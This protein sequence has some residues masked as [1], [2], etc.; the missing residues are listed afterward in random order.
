M[1][2]CCLVMARLLFLLALSLLPPATVDA[3]VV[4]KLKLQV[5]PAHG[6]RYAL[7]G[8]YDTLMLDGAT[9]IVLRLGHL[10][11]R[12]P[13][14]TLVAKGRHLRHRASRGEPGIASLKINPRKR[15][16]VVKGRELVLSGLTGPLLVELGT[17]LGAECT[18]SS[19]REASR[20]PGTC[21]NATRRSE[22]PWRTPRHGSGP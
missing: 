12:V 1:G 20:Q 5:D 7:S 16:F 4:E 22:R 3:L 18:I 21:S 9:D 14:A 17:D 13:A 11:F 10:E 19:L 8:R 15:A 6:D 2:R